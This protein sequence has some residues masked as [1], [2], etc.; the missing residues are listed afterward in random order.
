METEVVKAYFDWNDALRRFFLTESDSSVKLLCV[1]D[2]ILDEI[3]DKYTIAKPEDY[4]FHDHFRNSVA[5]ANEGRQELLA[6]FSR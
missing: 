4:T 3:G 2:D 5:L 6:F 1:D